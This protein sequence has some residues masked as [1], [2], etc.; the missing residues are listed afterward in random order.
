MGD[1]AV[2]PRIFPG[3]LWGVCGS[4]ITTLVGVNDVSD[5]W[6]N[7]NL[8]IRTCVASDGFSRLSGG[9]GTCRLESQTW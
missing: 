3:E 9:N 4:P 6:P 7:A 8:F 5:D 2:D 1:P